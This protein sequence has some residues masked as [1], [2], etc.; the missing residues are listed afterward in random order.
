MTVHKINNF[1]EE[2]IDKF[3]KHQKEIKQNVIKK[4]L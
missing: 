4:G 3:Y 1:I 2:N